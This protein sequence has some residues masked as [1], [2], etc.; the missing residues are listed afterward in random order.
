[1]VCE[2]DEDLVV[3]INIELPT[4]HLNNVLGNHEV[5][6]GDGLQR[7]ARRSIVRES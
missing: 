4:E 1:M 5:D 7:C 6:G 2:S 3:D